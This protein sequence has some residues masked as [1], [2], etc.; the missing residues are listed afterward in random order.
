MLGPRY[1]IV[2][3]RDWEDTD[4][5][6]LFVE[7]LVEKYGGNRLLI[8]SG[9][10]GNVDKTAI[11]TARELKVPNLEIPARWHEHGRAA[12]PLRNPLIVEE[13]DHVVAFWDGSSKGTEDTI[14]HA[15]RE[16][17]LE[18]IVYL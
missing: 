18:R 15:M 16:N 8:I 14:K 6:R 17:K 1:A 9:D 4:R 12:G 11:K 3:S 7:E 5:I 2:G 13:S 10:G